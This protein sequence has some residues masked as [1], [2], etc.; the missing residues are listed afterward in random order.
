MLNNLLQKQSYKKI[1]IGAFHIHIGVVIVKEHR[2]E[3]NSGYCGCILLK[4]T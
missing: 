1:I 2:L 4:K 3:I